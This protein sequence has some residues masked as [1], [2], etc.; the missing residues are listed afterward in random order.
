M[1]GETIDISEYLDFVF[2]E[3]F[4]FKDNSSISPSY[5]GKWLGISHQIGRLVCYHILT[6]IG[7]VLS[8]STVKWVKNI[9]LSTDEV[10]ETF[11]KFYT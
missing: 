2:Y 9:E 6:Q 10:K 3:K 7:K 4:E 11:V 8:R 5:P 1:T